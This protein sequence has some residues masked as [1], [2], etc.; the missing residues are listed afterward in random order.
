MLTLL[1]NDA[2]DGRG[3]IAQRTLYHQAG[4]K[5]GAKDPCLADLVA[6]DRVGER[7]D[8]LSFVLPEGYETPEF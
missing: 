6:L 4:G 3:Q 8:P 5:G 2:V 7:C 1:N